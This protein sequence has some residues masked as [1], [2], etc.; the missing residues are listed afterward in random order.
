MV[1]LLPRVANVRFTTMT[2]RS[3]LKTR[4]FSTLSAR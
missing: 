2:E 3:T 1:E 4:C